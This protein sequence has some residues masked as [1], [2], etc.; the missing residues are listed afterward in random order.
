[1]AHSVR[2]GEYG[3]LHVAELLLF[4]I[5]YSSQRSWI[6]TSEETAVFSDETFSL[7][8]SLDYV[9]VPLILFSHRHK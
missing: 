1:L 6:S 4:S 3:D 5:A 8:K 2:R 7:Q 9:S